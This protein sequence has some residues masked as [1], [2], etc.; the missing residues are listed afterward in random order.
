MNL[1]NNLEYRKLPHGNEKIGVLGLGMGGIQNT[2]PD[3]IQAVVGRALECSVF[4]ML[5]H[6]SLCVICPTKANLISVQT[7]FIVQSP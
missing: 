6:R 7:S 1:K 2:S 4:T 3:E 5:N